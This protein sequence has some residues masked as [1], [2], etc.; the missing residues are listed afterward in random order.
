MAQNIESFKLAQL[1]IR[2]QPR[3]G[4][5]PTVTTFKI[6]AKLAH[7]MAAAGAKR[8]ARKSEKGGAYDT[9]VVRVYT[10][11]MVSSNGA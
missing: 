4:S 2:H 3:D 10:D 8:T 6:P 11:S 5:A 1:E 9:I 7:Q